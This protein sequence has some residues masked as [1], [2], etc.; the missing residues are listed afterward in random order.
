MDTDHL[1]GST[2][3]NNNTLEGILSADNAPEACADDNTSV[4]VRA[5]HR[6]P[7]N[8]TVRG[9][10]MAMDWPAQSLGINPI[11]HLWHHPKRKMAEYKI[12]PKRILKLWNRAEEEWN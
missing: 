7:Y 6:N 11:E 1:T 10:N 2:K 4:Y 3:Q 9:H 5:G 8:R 12:P